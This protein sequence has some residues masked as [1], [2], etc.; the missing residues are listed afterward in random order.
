[1]FGKSHS[2]LT[3]CA[4]ARYIRDLP[5]LKRERRVLVECTQVIKKL[6]QDPASRHVCGR[7]VEVPIRKQKNSSSPTQPPSYLFGSAL[8]LKACELMPWGMRVVKA[9]AYR[10]LRRIGSVNADVFVFDTGIDARNPDLRIASARSFV[11][12]EPFVQDMNG[13]GTAVSGVIGALDNGR[14]VVGMAPGV[15]LHSMK[16]LDADGNGTMGDIL[17]GI[18]AMIAWKSRRDWVMRQRWNL[19]QRRI[20]VRRRRPFRALNNVVANFSLGAFAGTSEDTVLDQ[21]IIRAV[22]QGITCVVAAGNESLNA[23]L[24]TPAHCKD[25]ICVASYGSDMRFSWWSNFGESVAVLAPGEG[26]L[27]TLNSQG[28]RQILAHTISGTSFACPHVSGAAAL[29]LARNPH[30]SPSQVLATILAHAR[31]AAH[32]TSVAQPT[33]QDVPPSTT[34]L[35]ITAQWL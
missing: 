14:G 18:D 11:R 29:L 33:I 13:H 7:I 2:F 10:H 3:K 23:D 9:P 16:V 34:H 24:V 31:T 22:R 8:R 21:A 15:R 25:A 26:I 4:Q 12:H 6:I 5:R 28:R 17:R 27:T 32:H 35:S 1:M 30:A 19:A 20:A